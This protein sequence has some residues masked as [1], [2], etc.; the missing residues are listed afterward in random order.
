M[1]KMKK[2]PASLFRAVVRLYGWRV[3][4]FGIL[5][6]IEEALKCAQPIFMG[7]LIRYFRFDAPLSTD[8]ALMAATGVAL[9]SAIFAI[10]H[11]PYFYGLQ[12]IGLELKVA[13]CGMIMQ[14]VVA[15]PCSNS[16]AFI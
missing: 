4:K 3:M 5:L 8:E 16:R 11:H 6:L 9:T 7:R 12:K 10:I 14:K 2:R 13:A 1:A 15:F